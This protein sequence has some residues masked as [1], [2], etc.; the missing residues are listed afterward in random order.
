VRKLLAEFKDF[1]MRGNVLDL[2][3]GIIIGVAFSTVV[4]SL[5]NDILMPPIGY[6]LNDVDFSDLFLNISGGDYN[7]LAEAQAA[8]AATINYGLFINNVITF[9]ITALAVFL[10]IKQLNRF[11]RKPSAEPA[12]PTVKQCPYCKSNIDIAATRCPQCTSQLEGGP[13]ERASV[14]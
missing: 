14:T 13:A 4:N 8:G 6:I 7:S 2:A 11:L 12:A 3:V 5:V 9:L 1:A 10:V